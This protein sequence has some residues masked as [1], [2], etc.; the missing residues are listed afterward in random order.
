M[1]TLEEELADLHSKDAALVFSSGYVS[2]QAGISTLGRLLPDGLL[3]SDQ[4][5][6]NSMI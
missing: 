6:H 1:V 3:I 2:N 4:L 5:N